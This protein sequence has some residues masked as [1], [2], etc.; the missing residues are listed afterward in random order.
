MARVADVTLYTGVLYQVRMEPWSSE[1]RRRDL[2]SRLRRRRTVTWRHAAI[3]TLLAPALRSDSDF[4]LSALPAVVLA[5]PRPPRLEYPCACATRVLARGKRLH[6][7]PSSCQWLFR[8]V[9]L[10][11][12]KYAMIS[13]K[14]GG[15]AGQTVRYADAERT[16]RAC[17]HACVRAYVRWPSIRTTNCLVI[18][19]KFRKSCA[20]H[21][22][23]WR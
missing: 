14:F 11:L 17:V 2:S 9:I 15:I 20:R 5:Q 23:T 3:S 4:A 22:E 1:R 10:A 19:H 8:Y 13:C 21:R 16:V 6:A 7:A 12:V 18:K